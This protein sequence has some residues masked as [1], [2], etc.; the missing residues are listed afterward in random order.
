MFKA[1]G[2]TVFAADLGGTNVEE[3]NSPAAAVMVIG[4]EAHGISAD[5]ARLVDQRV[6]VDKRAKGNIVE[7]LNAAAASS[8][9]M[10]R[11]T[12]RTASRP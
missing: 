7:S 11:W 3:W 8:I 9:I 6:V 10:E 5:V 12:R 4:S 1:T 2:V